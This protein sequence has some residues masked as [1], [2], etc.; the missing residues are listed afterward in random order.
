MS[1]VR[2]SGLSHYARLLPLALAS[3]LAL[4]LSAPAGQA[5]PAPTAAPTAAAG[6]PS[7]ARSTAPAPQPAPDS[8]PDAREAERSPGAEVSTRERAPFTPAA[9]PAPG[10]SVSAKSLG[11]PARAAAADCSVSAFT[12]RT[13]S[14]LVQQIK[15]VDGNCINTLFSL[16]GTNAFYAF[17][18]SQMVTVANALRTNAASYPGDNSTSTYQLVMFLRAGYYAQWYHP[19]D[20]GTYGTSLQSAIRGALD[21]YFAHTR[22]RD[23]TTA[24]ADILGQSI[25]LIDSA[26]ENTRYLPVVKRLLTDY[27]AATYNTVSGMPGA[28]NSI[29]NT[30]W[31]GHE[32]AG[33]AAAV[34]ADPSV[35]DTLNGFVSANTALLGTDYGY[36][37]YNG[38]RE[39]GRF[40]QHGSL[41]PK[42][43]PLLSGLTAQSAPSGRTAHLWAAVSEMVSAYDAADAA[44]YG[45][46][47]GA[48]RLR[49]GILVT[50]HTCSPS[51]R[52]LAQQVTADNLADAC[53]S[54]L[55]QDEY[56]HAVARDRGPVAND[57]NT[58]IEVVAFDTRFDYQVFAAAI[59]RIDTNNG[60]MYLEGNP[61]VAGNQPRFLAYENASV[62]PD[63]QVWNLNH[64]YT[65]YLDGRFNM[66][67]DFNAGVSTPTIWWIE[68]FAEY[69]SY[70]YLDQPYT[71]ATAAAG[72]RTYA[73][74]TLFDT[75]YLNTNSERTYRWGYLAVRYMMEKHR[76]DVDA[77]LAKYRAG[78]WAGART[79]LKTTIGT[80]YDADFRTWLTACAAGACNT[81]PSLPGNQAPV[82][83]FTSTVSGLTATLTDGSTDYDGTVASR[84]WNFG[85]GT[86][87]TEAAPVKA[88]STAGSYTVTL[89]VTD[90]KG[91]TATVS[92]QVDVGLLPLCAG[93]DNRPLGRNCR[94]ADL[95]ATTGNISHHY[96]NVP[97]GTKQL[98]ITTTGGTGN[99]DLY[100]NSRTWTAPN[101]Y[102]ARS[103]QPG[104]TET[105]TIDN[106]P[107]GY[108]YFGLHAQE[109][110]TGAS[111]SVQY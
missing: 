62:K 46:A 60:G 36:L 28:I 100:Y 111:I 66:Y 1:S 16:T 98:R 69:V 92:K 11:A 93:T 99:A 91:T 27:N 71:A 18:E 106:P 107:T 33:F 30:L 82:A 72:L 85:D 88:Y 84:S 31:R 78:D 3:C 43:Q 55:A 54:L 103:A 23:V 47:D 53:A 80:R 81:T 105:L 10:T 12:G 35:L 17:Q 50:T 52:I 51:I 38:A 86:T 29:F 34:Q 102:T 41:Q 97:A 68:G 65:H 67:G 89:T 101:A 25:T 14:A 87:S 4:G 32:V 63:F 39:L 37:V 83:A 26:Q 74:S 42:L 8:N 59:Y 57:L 108:V 45:T 22:S 19:T 95:S 73:L 15:A 9:D 64:E 6:T 44:L 90:D 104:N 7:A 58:G 56:F 24:N 21:T 61:A 79:L 48:A 70:S 110:F 109:G 94:R 5:A 96:L 75:T 77:V 76:P 2:I 13:G 49:A 40:L 20:V